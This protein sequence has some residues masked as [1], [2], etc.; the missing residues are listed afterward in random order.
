[1][2]KAGP[3]EP[4]HVLWSTAP[5]SGEPTHNP[6][7]P[8]QGAANDPDSKCHSIRDIHA[9]VS[10]SAKRSHV[11]RLDFVGNTIISCWSLHQLRRRCF[12]NNGH[13]LFPPMIAAQ[14]LSNPDAVR[15]GTVDSVNL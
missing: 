2:L 7:E 12:T 4:L 10:G 8:Q 15:Q 13:R 3:A 9:V 1:M 5:Q 11:S 6:H 14:G